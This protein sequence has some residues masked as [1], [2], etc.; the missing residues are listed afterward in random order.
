MRIHSNET[1]TETDNPLFYIPESDSCEPLFLFSD[2]SDRF[3]HLSDKTS[4]KSDIITCTF[5]AL[6]PNDRNVAACNRG[7][8]VL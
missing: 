3:G 5:A 6:F 4:Y 2:K 7:S 8:D 1:S